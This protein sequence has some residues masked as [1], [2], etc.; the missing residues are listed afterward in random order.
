MSHKLEF[1]DLKNLKIEYHHKKLPIIGLIEPSLFWSPPG[2]IIPDCG[3]V[4]NLEYEFW[5]QLEAEKN[6][7]ALQKQNSTYFFS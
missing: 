4:E 2:L 1:R 5:M 3:V 6:N 7:F